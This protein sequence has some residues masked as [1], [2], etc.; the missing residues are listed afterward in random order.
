[1]EDYFLTL[2]SARL[3][4]KFHDECEYWHNAEDLRVLMIGSD[5]VNRVYY[6]TRTRN[7]LV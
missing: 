2:G 7:F 1:M 3:R 5:L 4:D 6:L